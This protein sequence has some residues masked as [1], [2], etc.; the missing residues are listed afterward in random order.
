MNRTCE[1]SEAITLLESSVHPRKHLALLSQNEI[2]Q[3]INRTD[4]TLYPLIRN[5]ALAVLNSG[6]M[7]DDGLAL[8][9]Q[10]PD[11]DLEFERHSRGLKVILRHAPAQAFVD[12]KLIETIHDQLFAVLRDLLHGRDPSRGMTQQSSDDSTDLVFQILRNAQVL[13]S[14]SN[15]SCIVCWGGHSINQAE[16]DYSQAVGQQL[17]LRRF[18]I[19]TGCGP[20]AMKGPMRGAMYAH[21]R[22]N[23]T[24]GRFIGISE[25]GIIAAE[26]PNGVVSELVIMPDI[27][28]RLEAFV[29]IAHGIVIFPGG[30]GTLEEI[31]YLLAILA[32]PDNQ[33]DP[34]PIILTGPASSASTIEA[35]KAFL[36]NTLGEKVRSRI[37]IIIDNPIDVA[38]RIQEG[39]SSVKAHRKATNDAYYFN[40]T[41]T[42][43]DVL[44][45]AFMP[46]HQSMR[47]LNLNPDSKPEQLACELRRLFSGIVAGNVKPETR[48]L[49]EAD[50]P[51]EICAET[52]VVTAVDTLLQRLIDENR[53][54][55]NGGYTPC[56]KLLPTS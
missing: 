23:H 53:M 35:Y 12:G 28:K 14:N 41:L 42:I 25:P 32:H 17:G 13:E 27:E 56:Y 19:C 44:Q 10:Y 2:D 30:A 6:V 34:L 46:T 54:K 18:D 24:S 55:V 29:R 38:T 21:S 40:W 52:A 36:D 4:K 11:F 26:P 37:E 1:V 9:A 22:Q 43:T 7:S 47:E 20:G 31:L 5:C 16:Y 45:T 50:G 49:I 3:L 8:F 48:A 51:F 33:L 39:V 15:L